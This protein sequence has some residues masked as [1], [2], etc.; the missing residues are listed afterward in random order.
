MSK[1]DFWQALTEP[2]DKGCFNCVR[3]DVHHS[4]CRSIG[5]DGPMSKYDGYD[6][7]DTVAKKSNW[8]T[9]WKYDPEIARKNRHL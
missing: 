6:D 4:V 7:H 1:K 2:T 3:Y 9:Q 5:C 8:L